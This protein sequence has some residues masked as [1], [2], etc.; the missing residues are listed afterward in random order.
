MG[1]PSIQT[2]RFFAFQVARGIVGVGALVAL[3]QVSILLGLLN[4][5]MSL[6]LPSWLKLRACS[7]FISSILHVES[8]LYSLSHTASHS[9]RPRRL[10][11]SKRSSTTPK[12]IHPHKV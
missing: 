5:P 1:P 4:A 2:R 11:W 10:I 8:V 6:F 9:A 3:A 12:P 7:P